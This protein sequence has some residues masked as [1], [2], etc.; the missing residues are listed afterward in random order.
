MR[1]FLFISSFILLVVSVFAVD[2]PLYTVYELDFTGPSYTPAGRPAVEVDLY[3]QWQH[4]SGSPTYKIWGFWDGNGQGG[5]TGNVFKVRFCPTKTGTWTLINTY[6]NKPELNNENEGIQVNCVSSQ[7][8]G[9]WLAAGR[10]FK[11][12]D[13]S[14]QYVAGNTHYSFLTRYT[15]SGKLSKTIAQDVRDNSNYYNKLRF[16]LALDYTYNDP[17][18]KPFFNSSGGLSTSGGDA[19]RPNPAWFHQ[20]A[21]QAVQE[22]MKLDFICDLILERQLR[23]ILKD[24]YLKYVAA[25]Y[26]SYPNVWITTAIEWDEIYSASTVRERGNFLQQYLPYPTPVTVHGLG[27]VWNSSLNGTWHTHACLQGKYGDLS[28][29]AD[30]I[31]NSVV[32][33]GG[34]PT[35][36]DE[37][38]YQGEMS[39]SG[40]VEGCF[41]SFMGGGYSTNGSKTASKASQYFWGNFDP[42]VHTASYNLKYMREYIN[43]N[44]AF[45]NLAP[46]A[47]HIFSGLNSGFRVLGDGAT[48]FVLGTDAAASGMSAS[49]GTTPWKITRVDLF[50][51]STTVLAEQATG[52][53]SFS[54]PSS[55][56]VMFHFKKVTATAPVIA[57]SPV[58]VSNIYVMGGPNPSPGKVQ[59]SNKGIGTLNWSASESPGVL[60]LSLSG[61]SGQDSG[62]ITLTYN[63]ASLTEGTHTCDIVIIAHGAENSPLSIPVSLQVT[64]P[65]NIPDP[66]ITTVDSELSSGALGAPYNDDLEATGGLAPLEWT[67]LTPLPPG[68]SIENKQLKGTPTQ[69]GTFT[70]TVQVRDARDST[71]RKTLNLTIL[72][73]LIVTLVEYL[74]AR[75]A[76]TVEVDGFVEGAKQANDRYDTW[77]SVPSTLSGLTYL[78]TARDDKSYGP[79]ENE[80]IYRVSLNAPGTV[81]CLV[82]G[83]PSWLSADGWI[84][85]SIPGPVGNNVTYSV[86]SKEFSSGIIGLKR[87]MDGGSQGTSYVFKI[88]SEPTVESFASDDYSINEPALKVWPNPFSGKAIIK[89]KGQS[90]KVKVQIFNLNGKMIKNFSSIYLPSGRRGIPHTLYLQAEGLSSGVY[91]L[92]AKTGNRV[93]SKKLILR[94]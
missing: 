29:A 92:K 40:V 71:D 59:I 52:N 18:N 16:Y 88:G 75:T 63:T 28:A 60:W 61:A 43:A 10:W 62:G 24:A 53:Y 39:F 72:D 12:S 76:P 34:K 64:D 4:E 51:K 81:Y 55:N 50:A 69:T 23:A 67:A 86:Y 21:D 15:S 17:N 3:T 74:G 14:H 70:F 25:R 87:Y 7:E 42:T 90:S 26:G 66:V 78:L 91:I 30:L 94:K 11:R 82:D 79:V 41:G 36:N 2:V 32:S 57:A 19:E 46:T 73:K 68:L 65:A 93:L 77:S 31:K 20:K 83:T 22:G 27:G 38:G 6:S 89:F 58:A 47:N 54:S 44:V 45:W 84:R 80:A 8:H 85:T 5:A 48:E 37:N 1:W 33:A 13:G 56:A 49:L 9:F 35:I